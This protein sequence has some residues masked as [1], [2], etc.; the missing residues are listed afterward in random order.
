MAL[1][2]AGLVL[3]VLL[4]MQERRFADPLLPPRLFANAVFV[5]GVGIAFCA[6]LAL[7][8]GSF[9]LP[10]F[11]QLVMGVDAASS[12]ALVVPF[13]AANCVGAIV[14]GWL[15]RRHGKMKAIMVAGLASC[16]V[17]FALLALI[18]GM[19]SRVPDGGLP[20]RVGL[21]HRAW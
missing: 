9:L 15:A 7:F 3:I 18:D 17:G 8:G 2:A 5:R 1:G 19:T 4:A 10:L 14:A 20:V 21:R 13:L 11:F 16:L 12:G 6:S